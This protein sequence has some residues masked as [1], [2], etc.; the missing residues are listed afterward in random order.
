MSLIEQAAKRLE[1]LQRAGAE[2]P[3]A[4]RA[5]ATGLQGETPP[6]PEAFMRAL[7]ARAVALAR[8]MPHRGNDHMFDRRE[9]VAQRT[10]EHPVRRIELD[11]AQVKE[12]GFVTLDSL[13]SQIADEFRVLKRPIIRNALGREGT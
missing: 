13:K 7:D 4:P 5:G 2:L 9:S 11:L 8:P 1:E 3:D 12:R 10:D 6:T